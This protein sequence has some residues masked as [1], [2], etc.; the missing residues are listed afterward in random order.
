MWAQRSSTPLGQD[1]GPDPD[2]DRK[3]IA[4]STGATQRRSDQDMRAV[5]LSVGAASIAIVGDEQR[6]PLSATIDDPVASVSASEA[7][8]GS[9][10]AG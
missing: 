6:A 9:Y 7:T 5:G 10:G 2:P 8:A 1:P 4:V 3:P